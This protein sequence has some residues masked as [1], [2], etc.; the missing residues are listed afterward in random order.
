MRVGSLSIN[1]SPRSAEHPWTCS[2][3]GLRGFF[4]RK[5]VRCSLSPDASA[6]VGAGSLQAPFLVFAH[7]PAC[8]LPDVQPRIAVQTAPRKLLRG[9]APSHPHTAVARLAEFRRSW[10]PGDGSCGEYDRDDF[11]PLSSRDP[12]VERIRR[13]ALAID[14]PL[15]PRGS[16]CL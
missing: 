9:T 16:P 11:G 8:T 1:V 2:I 4:G 6:A 12:D 3:S 7:S 15:M 5:P 10:N 14:L 13:S